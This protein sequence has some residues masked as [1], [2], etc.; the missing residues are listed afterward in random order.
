[1]ISMTTAAIP[2]LQVNSVSCSCERPDFRVLREKRKKW[3]SL[4]RVGPPAAGAFKPKRFHIRSPKY[5][6]LDVF[7]ARGDLAVWAHQWTV[8]SDT[9]SARATCGTYSSIPAWAC[10]ESKTT[11]TSREMPGGQR[12]DGFE[13]EMELKFH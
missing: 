7:S 8:L 9:P 12:N 5:P 13:I 2:V 6:D 4:A 3:I 1:M 10:N 11:G